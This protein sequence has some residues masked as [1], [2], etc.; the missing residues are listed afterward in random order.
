MDKI[1]LYAW[2]TLLALV[3]LQGQPS[4]RVVGQTDAK[5]DTPVQNYKLEESNLPRALISV[6]AQFHIPM[7]IEWIEPATPSP[8]TLSWKQATVRQVIR[9]IVSTQGNY[10]V[11]M[12]DMVHVFYRGAASDKTNFLNIRLARFEMRNQYTALGLRDLHRE[13][14]ARM[15]D[16][17]P[18]QDWAGETM[19]ELDD[20]RLN[21]E[22]KQAT[23]REILDRLVLAASRPIWS[24]TFR[25]QAGL[26]AGGFRRTITLW[27]DTPVLDP[28]QPVWDRMMW[29][30]PLP[31]E[32]AP[33]E[34]TAGNSH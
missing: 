19:L 5:L 18:P 16:I 8:V 22:F 12:G 1:N 25:P 32:L 9:S 26:T 21:M 24:V 10:D 14:N 33:K 17:P 28:Y 4:P 31:P 13:V 20:H 2:T 7:G 15:R 6:A 34:G 11:E 23:V 27:N 29:G 3:G 30:R